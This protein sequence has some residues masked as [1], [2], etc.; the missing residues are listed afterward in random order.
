MYW[1]GDYVAISGSSSL[2]KSLGPLAAD[3]VFGADLNSSFGA[4]GKSSLLYAG[5]SF[6]AA[7][8]ALVTVGETERLRLPIIS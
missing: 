5:T 1:R 7:G 6:V 4:A 3:S 2:L 8:S